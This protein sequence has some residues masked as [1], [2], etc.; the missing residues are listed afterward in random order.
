MAGG[1]SGLGGGWDSLA[2]TT[3]C[4]HSLDLGLGEVKEMGT[5]QPFGALVGKVGKSR[6]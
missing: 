3:L 4:A 6:V 5:L 1:G 2:K